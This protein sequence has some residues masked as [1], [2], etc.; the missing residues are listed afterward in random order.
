MSKVLEVE[1]R[2]GPVIADHMATSAYISEHLNQQKPLTAVEWDLLMQTL[3][4]L[5]YFLDDW[6]RE[7]GKRQD[8]IQFAGVAC[9]ARSDMLSPIQGGSQNAPRHEDMTLNR[10]TQ[11]DSPADAP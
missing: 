5:R 10:N 8:L 3:T 1:D 11:R 7:N 9:S 6:K 4:S 2:I